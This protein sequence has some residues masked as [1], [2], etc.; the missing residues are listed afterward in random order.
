MR[1]LNDTTAVLKQVEETTDTPVEVIT[2]PSLPTYASIKIARGA[3]THH[4]LTYN[5]TK[6]GVDYHVVYQCGF[7]L[8]LFENS[9]DERY[10]FAGTKTGHEVVRE[11]LAEKGGVA[12]KLRLPQAARKQ[13]ANQF[14]DGLLVQLRSYPIGMRI[15]QWIRETFPTLHEAQEASIDRQQRDN[16]QALNPQ[17]RQMTPTLIFSANASMNAAYAIFCERLLNWSHYVIPYRSLGFEERGRALLSVSDEL[18]S[19]ARH[20]RDLVDAWAKDLDV[21]D[22]YRWIPLTQGSN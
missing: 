19:D 2:D 7:I 18:P 3:A 8:R 17:I 15:D 12:K 14:V 22:W 20:D 10:E 16:A 6:P 1:M 5:P 4:I 21:S 13:L 9:Q 11:L